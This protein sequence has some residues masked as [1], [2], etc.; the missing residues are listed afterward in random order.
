MDIRTRYPR[1]YFDANA[2]MERRAFAVVQGTLDDLRALGYTPNTAVGVRFTFVQEDEDENGEPDA[3]I[4]HGTIVR[5]VRPGGFLIL[6][7]D[8]GIR[9]LSELNPEDV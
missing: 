2:Q 1:L 7:D 6:A 3:L 4:F 5:S 8:V 9:W